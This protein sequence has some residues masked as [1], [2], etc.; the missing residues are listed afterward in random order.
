[1]GRLEVG[2]DDDDDARAR[3]GNEMIYTNYIKL[4]VGRT[5]SLPHAE[6][7]NWKINKNRIEKELINR[8]KIFIIMEAAVPKSLQDSQEAS[9]K[10]E[11]AGN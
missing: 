3:R 2:D 5:V 6:N 11:E 8:L 10:A 9:M 7:I 1:M 4:Q